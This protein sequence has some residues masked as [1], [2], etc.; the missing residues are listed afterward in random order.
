MEPAISMKIRFTKSWKGY[1]AGE[2][3]VIGGGVADTLIRRGIAVEETQQQLIETASLEPAEA[4]RT[5]DA[6]PKRRARK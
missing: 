3:T 2:I 6:T 1:A 4:V 5:A